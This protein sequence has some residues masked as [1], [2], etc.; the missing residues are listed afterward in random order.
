VIPPG[1]IQDLLSRVDIVEVV[2]RHVELK[3]A[4]INH[5][6]LCP[7]HG[8]KS[9]SFIVSPTRQT[10]HCFG[11]GVHGNAV[12]FLMEHSGLG[13]VE[14]VQDLAQQTGMQVPEDER[15]SEERER[16]AQQKQRQATLTEVL[17]RAS[18][19]YRA[20]LKKTPRAIDYLK[21]RGLTGQIAAQFA[22][23]YAPEGWR[24]L[25]SAFPSYDDPLLTES[26][27]VITQGEEGEEQK[28]YDRFRDRIMFPIRN[29]QGETIGFGGRVLDKG[30][31]KYLNSPE[32]PVFS[33]GRELYGL[34]EARQGLRQRGYA[35]VVE[36]YMDVVAL[37]QH[38]FNNAVATLG[39]A[40]TA[41]H[42]L[43]LFRF[44][45]SVIFSFDG[46][47]A[48]RRAAGRALEAA[49]PHAT[50]VR[51]VKFL[52]LPTE[53]DPDSYVRDLGADAFENCIAQ[54]VPLSRQLME[55]AGEGC[56]LSSAEGRARMLATARPLW[57]TLPQ[58]LLKRQLLGDLAR[59]AQ[60]PDQELMGLWQ[61]GVPAPQEQPHADGREHPP[62]EAQG[63]HSGEA[64][65]FKKK[66]WK[67]DWKPGGN[68]KRR[69]EPE[70]ET[71]GTPRSAPNVPADHA[72]RMLLLNSAW[73]EKL[74]PDDHQLL[75]ELPGIH[76]ELIN[77]L[78]R[79]LLNH[80]SGAWSVLE[81]A[82]LEDGLLDRAQRLLGGLHSEDESEF[83]GLQNLL[84][85]LWT[86]Q[87]EAEASRIA[88]SNPQG[89]AFERYKRLLAQIKTL[90]LPSNSAPT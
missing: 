81:A 58:G 26:G 49:L 88:A 57:Q 24:S 10:Y 30:E 53:H 59:R 65:P 84:K 78:D 54:A 4:G 79:Y 8:E 16:A 69:G 13:F 34:Y 86:M 60:L 76:G 6:G 5:K 82:L 75:H 47:A 67:K 20:Q 25:A 55:V 18:D 74:S 15:S 42:V 2:G 87:L 70:D 11:C 77:W 12:G 68:W 89:E 7:F 9:P 33:K 83:E 35:L 32:T 38:G 71:M 29:V 21:N 45:E 62:E 19:H 44:T 56:D 50:D 46:D 23:G 31:P 3:K 37:A 14:A 48:G 28:R 1:F 36:G 40:C 80:G 39:T 72:L 27:M 73:W 61:V 41:E 63:S 90:K 64:K 51:T 52:F 17:L 85:R 66:E 22:L 43:K